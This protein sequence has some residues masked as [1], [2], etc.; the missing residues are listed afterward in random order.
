[1]ILD[2]II[3]VISVKLCFLMYNN[4]PHFLIPYKLYKLIL[5][6]WPKAALHWKKHF[7][8]CTNTEHN[9]LPTCTSNFY[10]RAD[11]LQKISC[12]YTIYFHLEYVLW[13]LLIRIQVKQLLKSPNL[14][15]EIFFFQIY[16]FN[17]YNFSFYK[18]WNILWVF[19]SE[20][21]EMKC[22]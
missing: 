18:P 16:H 19:V 10:E 15:A 4:T 22:Y 17:C 13:D 2:T 9:I 3:Q 8:K 11:S 7:L 1:M 6:K 5:A 20:N 12:S 14:W 21:H